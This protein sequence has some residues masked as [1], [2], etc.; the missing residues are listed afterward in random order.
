MPPACWREGQLGFHK[1]QAEG[2]PG[3]AL[4]DLLLF[5]EKHPSA[6]HLFGKTGPP[7]LVG[8]GG[9]WGWIWIDLLSLCL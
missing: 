3:A 6:D 5:E 9:C 1:P 7:S 4:G 8:G 2:R